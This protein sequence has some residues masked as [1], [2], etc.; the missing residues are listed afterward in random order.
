[1]V[2]TLPSP[3]ALRAVRAPPDSRTMDRLIITG[4][5]PARLGRQEA[6]EQL[7]ERR[8]VHAG[9]GV[10]HVDPQMKAGR[11][12]QRPGPRARHPLL[13]PADRQGARPIHGV[14][15]VGNEVREDLEEVS[16][17]DR[18]RPA[19]ESGRRS[20]PA[21]GDRTRQQAGQE[22]GGLADQRGDVDRLLDHGTAADGL[23]HVVGDAQRHPDPLAQHVEAAGEVVLAEVAPDGQRLRHQP[24]RLERVLD[25]VADMGHRAAERRQMFELLLVQ[26]A[27]AQA[28]HVRLDADIGHDR[29]APVADGGQVEVVEEGRPVLAMVDEI[30]LDGI[31]RLERLPNAPVGDRI[32]VRAAQEAAVAADDLRPFEAGEFEEGRVDVGQRHVPLDRGDRVREVARFESGDEQAVRRGHRGSF[33]VTRKT[34]SSSWTCRHPASGCRA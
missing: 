8:G 17:P 15:R 3:T 20:V 25:L 31:A 34:L 13:R 19:G 30:D 10:G 16:R 28:R 22:G 2:K 11:E 6:L 9:A 18:N 24:D 29:P 5:L 14:E 21:E 4:A 23:E 12:A 33:E 1:M 27:L 32:G 7:G 26:Q